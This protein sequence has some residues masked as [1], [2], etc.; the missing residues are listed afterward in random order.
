MVEVR[1]GVSAV[2][3]GASYHA[4]YIKRVS[5]LVEMALDVQVCFP[6]TADDAAKIGEPVH[7]QKIFIRNLDWASVGGFHC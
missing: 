7:I 5:L 1:L 6:Y 4:N 2:G 3:G